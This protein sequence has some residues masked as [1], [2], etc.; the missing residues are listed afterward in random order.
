MRRLL[1]WIVVGLAL[2]CSE[3]R[4]PLS[5]STFHVRFEVAEHPA[6]DVARSVRVALEESFGARGQ[7]VASVDVRQPDPEAAL[8]LVR[9]AVGVGIWRGARL[10][11]DGET[12]RLVEEVFLGTECYYPMEPVDVGARMFE[13]TGCIQCHPLT[14]PFVLGPSLRGLIGAERRL[15]DGSTVVADEEYVRRVLVDPER[16]TLAGWEPSMPTYRGR[17]R[18]SEIE[19]L[20]A[21]LKSLD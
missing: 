1:G 11:R 18:E 13:M 12:W 10:E 7:E 4:E 14:P 20:V 9:L 3:E 8:A 17:F 6:T 19:G 5:P 15:S 16:P 21:Y 2:G